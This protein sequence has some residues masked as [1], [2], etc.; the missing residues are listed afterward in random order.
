MKRIALIVLIAGV[1]II[2]ISALMSPHYLFRS[3]AGIRAS[4]LK[5]TPL[6]TSSTDVRA[7]VDKQGWLVRNYV[8]NTGF[9][10]QK[11]DGPNDVVGVS[12]ICG[13]LGDFWNMNNTAFWGFD[14]RNQLIDIWVWRTFDAP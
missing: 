4:L 14:S 11:S 10:R 2:A 5:Q 1:V 8:G 12:S 6:G 13:N 7:F 9:L 3:E